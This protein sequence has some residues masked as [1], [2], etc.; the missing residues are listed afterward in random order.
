MSSYMQ[1]MVYMWDLLT[2]SAPH[3]MS[4]LHRSVA[5]C[6]AR[7]VVYVVYGMYVIDVVWY[8][9]IWNLLTR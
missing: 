8:I 3:V 1:F 2:G 6:D 4:R 9:Y 7:Y 5:L